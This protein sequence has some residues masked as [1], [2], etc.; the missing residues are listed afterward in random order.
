[1]W[2]QLFIF[3]MALLGLIIYP[4][5]GNEFQKK[6]AR[7]HYI[8]LMMVLLAIQSGFRHLSVGPDTFS[9]YLDFNEIRNMHLSD[10]INSFVN[11]V[12]N[13]EGKDPG[14]QVF[15]YLFALLFPSFRLFLF[16][17][18]G[19]LFTALGRLFYR[20]TNSNKEVLVAVAL[21][22]ALYYSFLSIT[23]IRQTIATIF[24][25]FA[26]PL[27][28]DRKYVKA[29]ILLIV[30]ATQHK[31]ALLFLPFVGL[32]YIKNSRILIIAAAITFV[33]MWKMGGSIASFFMAGTRFEQY[34][35]YLE[36]FEGA[37]A[38]N[39]TAF[40]V[41]LSFCMY[42][43]YFEIVKMY[44]NAYVFVNAVAVALALTPLTLIDPSNMRIVQYYSI[45]ALIVLPQFL[46]TI[47]NKFPVDPHIVVFLIFSIYTVFG[48]HYEYG[49][50]WQ[51]I[52]LNA[53][54]GGIMFNEFDV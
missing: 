2:L 5:V 41:L 6:L 15:Q 35:M 21:Y 44:D 36:G 25:L 53:N 30:A 16:A 49:F 22:Q 43:K 46:T 28:L 48:L 3:I 10:L 38:Y 4:E 20:F 9:F 51:N 24:L 50:F 8:I 52:P 13:D 14:F 47:R 27:I 39:F 7:K 54:Y 18:A 45:F 34:S 33:P 12:Q 17:I 37:G 19:F 42:I 11:F 23:G 1:M 26:V 29:M 31:S 40:I 32:P